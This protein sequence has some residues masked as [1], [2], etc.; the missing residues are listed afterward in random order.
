M[1]Y[2]KYDPVTFMHNN[3]VMQGEFWE[4]L[5]D[6]FSA[7]VLIRTNTGVSIWKVLFQELA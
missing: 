6:G 5:E 7:R 4:Y 2:K 1:K 3:Q